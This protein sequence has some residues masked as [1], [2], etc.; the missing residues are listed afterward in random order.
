MD[1]IMDRLTGRSKNGI[2][3]SRVPLNNSFFDG[4]HYFTGFVADRLAAYEDTGLMPGEITEAIKVAR[5]GVYEHPTIFGM[6]FEEVR[7]I[8]LIDANALI[9]WIEKYME[10]RYVDGIKLAINQMHTIDPFK[11]GRLSRAK[12]YNP[13][14]TLDELRWMDGEPIW[15]VTSGVEGSG[16][17]ELSTCETLCVCPL[18]QVLRCVTADGEV[19]DYDFGSYGKTW[20]AYRSKLK[21]V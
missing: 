21:E 1:G 5:G 10:E 14:L 13:P 9:G 15:T 12:P 17:W 8:R 20:L 18:R 19:T 2:A 11:H 16:R 7:E 4:G 3:F 6:P